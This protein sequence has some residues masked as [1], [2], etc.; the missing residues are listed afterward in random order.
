[1]EEMEEMEICYP[2]CGSICPTDTVRTGEAPAG[3]PDYKNTEQ[4]FSLSTLSL[5]LLQKAGFSIKN[6]QELRTNGS[7]VVGIYV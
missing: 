2:G 4:Q 3:E 7:N 1:M 6:F 5:A